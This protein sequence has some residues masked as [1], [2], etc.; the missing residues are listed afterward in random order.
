MAKNSFL[1][2]L[3]VKVPK[4]S[5]FDKSFRNLLTMPVGTL[6]PLM[7]DEVI[8]NTQVDLSV[9]LNA[10]LPPLASETFMNVDLKLA[11][12]FIPFRLLYGGYT[13]WLTGEKVWN[14][15][16]TSYT[17]VE[18]PRLTITSAQASYIGPGSLADYLGFKMSAADLT[19]IG[20][21]SPVV[22]QDFNIFP[23]LAYHRF[24]DD[25]FRNSIIE[26]PVFNKPMVSSSNSQNNASI[27]FLP[28]VMMSPSSTN[29]SRPLTSTFNDGV[30][31]Y[32]LRQANFGLDLFTGSTPNAQ[33][34]SAQSITIDTSGSSTQ[35]SIA[36]IRTANSIQQWLERNLY[37]VKYQDFLHSNFGADLSDGVAQRSLYLGYGSVPV[38]TK[39][40]Y[41][42]APS[43]SSGGSV[44]TNNPF[45]TGV[46]AEYGSV[47]CQGVVHLIHDF[48]AQEPGL[49]FVMIWLSPE[50]TY[51]NGVDHQFLR[52][53]RN[54]SQV[55]MAN[56]LLQNVGQQPI[57]A[58]ELRGLDAFNNPAGVFGYTDRF[59]DFMTKNHEL[60]GLVRDG[61]SLQSFALQR[62][63]GSTPGINS[64]F[65]KIP[66]TYLDQVAA[67]PAGISNYGAWV[68]SYL[69]YR[70]AMPLAQ[71]SIPSLQD[72]SY[73]HGIDVTVKRGG[74]QI[75]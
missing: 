65:L 63:F 27:S 61:Y 37:S 36:S 14:N 55:D 49:V 34:G 3:T 24:Y 39:G 68:D 74:S 25:W 31:L 16:S 69:Q 23:F 17:D 28:Y 9:A 20:S 29:L 45:N 54:G 38:Y 32:D 35:L 13:S 46:G 52:Y 4:R 6:V 48:V 1:K 8:P 71:F 22:S 15:A 19:G 59:A 2:S 26:N 30:H 53:N 70:V 10:C 44:I 51:S 58:G 62:T 75:S 21:L 57:M 43:A 12:A 33:G 18:I 56:A 73:E 40:I 67:S 50:V 72:P 47:N 11:A 66:K 41:Q 64:S 60:H 5:A 42:Q 7:C